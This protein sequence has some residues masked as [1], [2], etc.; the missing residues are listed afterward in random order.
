VI[1]TNFNECE[2]VHLLKNRNQSA[3]NHLYQH[4]SSALYKIIH[5]IVS[6]EDAA[7]DVLQKVFVNVWQR[8]DAYESSKGRLFTWMLNIAR[9]A[10]IDTL[11]SRSFQSYRKQVYVPDEYFVN[12]SDC[13]YYLSI[14]SIGIEKYIARLKPSHRMLIELVYF[15]GY[16]HPEVA[17]MQAIPLSTIKTRVRTAI[18]QLRIL[19]G[20]EN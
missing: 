12:L 3:F 11:R 8:I 16:S 9:N 18:S 20:R 1:K 15:H 6:D 2:L 5:R 4:Y 7:A 17:A 10:A 14:D 13:S 19:I